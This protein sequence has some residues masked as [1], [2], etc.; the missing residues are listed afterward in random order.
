MFFYKETLIWRITEKVRLKNCG[1]AVSGHGCKRVKVEK[2][3]K[4]SDD[5]GVALIV[6]EDLQVRL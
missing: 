3:S 5:K 2:P 4:I 1:K 6:F